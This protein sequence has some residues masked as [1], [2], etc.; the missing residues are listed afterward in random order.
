LSESETVKTLGV[1]QPH[2]SNVSREMF[3][4]LARYCPLDLVMSPAPA[5]M[6]FQVAP[7][8]EGPRIRCF[9]GSTVMPLGKKFG[10][11][12]WSV[13]SYIL[14]ERP[15]ALLLNANPRYLTFWIALLWARALG[16]PVHA[17]GHGFYRRASVGAAYRLMMTAMLKLV[18]SYICYAPM[19]RQAFLDNG[20]SG[21]KLV[22]AH[23]SLINRFPVLPREKM[24]TEPG[25]LFIGRLRR[26]SCLHLLVRV[27]ERI[28]REDGWLLRL[29]VVG[30]GEEADA[31]RAEAQHYPWVVFH[32]GLYDAEQIRKVSLEC[33]AGCYPGTAGLSVVHMMSLSLPVITHNNLRAHGPE[34]SFIRDGVS[35]W[36]Y[37]HRDPEQSL[38]RAVRALASDPVKVAEMQQNAFAD[39][40]SLASPSLAERLWEIIAVGENAA[41]ENVAKENVAKKNQPRSEISKPQIPEEVHRGAELSSPAHTGA[42]HP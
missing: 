30:D 25:I 8:A 40:Q 3:L 16:I 29:H 19:V 36:L 14:R 23:N 35:G 28:R 41:S 39:Y 2:L 9:S 15:D 31:L 10:W 1:I 11:I 12:Q 5:G 7:L 20:F 34:P 21:G 32:G 17:H 37:D 38:Y 27:I 22:V 42:E 4:K 26:E 24:G 13:V 18:T 33:F 6:G